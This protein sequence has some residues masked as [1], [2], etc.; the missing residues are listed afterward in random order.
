MM[1]PVSHAIAII[2]SNTIYQPPAPWLGGLLLGRTYGGY[3]G[4][5]PLA[6]GP[7]VRLP[8]E[9]VYPPSP[10]IP[11]GDGLVG[12]TTGPYIG[13]GWY[14]V[15]DGGPGKVIPGTAG[16]GTVGPETSALDP[17][18]TYYNKLQHLG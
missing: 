9:V 2:T 17:C 3:P 14:S 10:A 7:D 4:S 8:G 16:P 6:P 12:S 11:A 18:L 13:L 1:F 5:D 15:W